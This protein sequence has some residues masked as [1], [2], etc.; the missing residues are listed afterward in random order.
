MAISRKP[1][2]SVIVLNWNG[3]KFLE[4]CISSLLR[5]SYSNYEIVFVDNGSTDGSVEFVKDKFGKSCRLK[6]LSLNENYGFAEGNNIGCKHA[7]GKYVIILNN[8]TEAQPNFIEELVKVAQTDEKVG[9]VGCRI[10]QYDGKTGYTPIFTNKGFI[11]P[12]FLGASTAEGRL[13]NVC[14]ISSSNLANC[15][16]AVLY[17][18][19]L[20][21]LLGGFDKDFWADWEDH[22]LGFR[23]NIAGFK[24]LFTPRTT[25]LHM[26][27]GSAGFSKERRTRLYKNM[28]FTY[29]KNF[30]LKTLVSHFLF[31]MF[32]LL[33]IGHF[34]WIF[35]NEWRLSR[36]MPFSYDRKAYSSLLEAYI[37]FLRKLRVFVKKRKRIQKLRKFSD[38]QIFNLTKM[39]CLI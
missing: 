12:F 15:G 14:G 5:Q 22:D 28:L 2:V 3:K 4:H 30:E 13:D 34:A 10:S 39:P 18:K 23:I 26:G 35:F 37:Q 8:D 20:F 21:D 36:K 6:I 33:P 7:K 16:C 24:S 38:T 25:V 11:V 17:R 27:G 29:I 31:F 9:S 19:D 32:F 1:L